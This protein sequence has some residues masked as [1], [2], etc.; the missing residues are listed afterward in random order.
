MLARFLI[1]GVRDVFELSVFS[2]FGG[3]RDEKAAGA[4]DDFQIAND[5]T[6]IDRDRDV[7]LQAVLVD[8]EYFHLGDD[9]DGASRVADHDASTRQFTRGLSNHVYGNL[10]V[11]QSETLKVRKRRWLLRRPVTSGEVRVQAHVGAA[12]IRAVKKERHRNT[13]LRPRRGVGVPNGFAV[14]E[15]GCALKIFVLNHKAPAGRV[16]Q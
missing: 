6:I 11:S 16:P 13:F 1:Q 5:E 14:G 8:G 9:H 2:F 3:H 10:E 7:S 15:V 12:G 4:F